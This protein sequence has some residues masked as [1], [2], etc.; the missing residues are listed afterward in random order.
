MSEKQSEYDETK[1]DLIIRQLHEELEESKRNEKD[2]SELTQLLENL[3]GR[4]KVL[5]E[6]K[7]MTF[8]EYNN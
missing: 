5:M 1:K 4:Y 8:G 3:E 7:V 2:F 6:E